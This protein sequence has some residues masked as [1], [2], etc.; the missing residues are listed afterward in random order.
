VIQPPPDDVQ[1][2]LDDIVQ[3]AGRLFEADNVLIFLIEG[4][5]YWRAA[6]IREPPR[7]ASLPRCAWLAIHQGL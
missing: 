4:D 1:A 6:S 5:G 3:S 7:P 2:V